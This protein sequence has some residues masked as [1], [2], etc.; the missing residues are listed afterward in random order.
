MKIQSFVLSLFAA[1]FFASCIGTDIVDDIV[2]PTLTIDNPLSS[3]AINQT[4]QFQAT[5]RN[6][7]GEKENIDLIWSSSDETI[8]SINPTTGLATGLQ[9]LA[10]TISVKPATLPSLSNSSEDVVQVAEQTLEENSNN[11]LSGKIMTTSSYLLEGDFTLEKNSG[12]D[13]LTLKIAQNY[14]A[15]TALPG[16]YI[17]LGNNPNTINNAFEIGAVTVF[18]GVH[19]YKLPNTISLADYKYVLYWCKPFRVKVGEGEIK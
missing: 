14:K 19:E 7:V 8:I 10:A 2:E 3:L 12:E 13:F 1:S 9:K 17:Y 5:Y 4:Y 6:N 11:I 16:L 18:E 15:S